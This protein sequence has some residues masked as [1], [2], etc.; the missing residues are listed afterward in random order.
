MEQA[1]II[2]SLLAGAVLTALAVTIG[3]VGTV[4]LTMRR[5]HG[6]MHLVFYIILL[7]V[8]LTNVLSGRDVTSTDL[9]FEEV[10]PLARQPL[11]VYA[12]PL[13]SLLLLI[14][15]SERIIAN[16]L[17]RENQASYFSL[18]A[19]AY[20][21]F[22]AGTVAAPA[23]LGAHPYFSHDYFYPLVIGMAAVLATKQESVIAIR[24]TR[25]ALLLFMIAGLLLIPVSPNLVIDF[26]YTQGL[27]PGVPRIT[28]L[29]SHAVTLGLLSQLCMLCLLTLPFKNVWSNRLAWSISFGMLFL[30]QSKSSWISFA[31]CAICIVVVQGSATFWRRVGNPLRPEFGVIF[32]VLFMGTL[33][34][35]AMILMFGEV[36]S[37]L[38]SFFD[39]AQGAQLVSLTGRDQIW[40]IAYEEWQRNPIFGYGTTLWDANFRMSIRMPNATTA[41]NQFMDSLSRSGT[42]GAVTLVFYAL[43]LLVQSVRY[44]RV[45][46]G[47]TLA[48]FVTL[49]MRS[50]SEVPLL[51]F[52]YST[53]L[54]PHV[55]LLMMLAGAANEAR[56]RKSLLSSRANSR[57]TLTPSSNPFATSIR[58]NQ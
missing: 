35:V 3:M 56:V 34:S 25:N 41:H 39:S 58:V 49:A 51:L 5:S 44:A 53:E 9:F 19:I 38:D 15:A 54:I 50:I 43:V 45:S 57:T 28:G 26:S 11:M 52:G 31:V 46:G 33:L 30:A 12:Q 40:A 32:I 42:V 13:A 27:L 21:L 17:K 8:A 10:A 22:W 2:S 48:L 47:L 4:Q 36:N 37:K 16:W 20:V 7:M 55:L 24:A 29:A 6:Y 18:L 14:V 1:I 23:F